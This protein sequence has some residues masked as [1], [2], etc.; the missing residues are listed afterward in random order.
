MRV[1]N[2]FIPFEKLKKGQLFL[3][4]VR[5]P[6]TFVIW[7][8]RDMKKFKA[9]IFDMDG[10]L[11]DTEHYYMKQRE[12]FFGGQGISISH[13]KNA[14]FIGRNLKEMWPEILLGDYEEDKAMALQ[15]AYEI[16][17]HATPLPY[18]ELLFPDVK[19]LLDYLKANHIKMAI[20]SSSSMQDIE[21]CIEKHDLA[22]YF[23]ALY[24]GRN[25]AA[26]KP[27]PAIYKA[28]IKGFGLLPEETLIIEDSQNGI[29]AGKDAGATVYAIADERFGMNQVRADKRMPNL[30][31]VLAQLKSE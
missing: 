16:K 6:N 31:A 13:L 10:V 19:P 4:K 14:D 25:F 2:Q 12:A 17:K 28:A 3:M 21:T 20:A 22:H 29:A 30:T 7:Y 23:S 5:R 18:E 9:V 27:N 11:V 24:S 8:N 1:R 26:S 15:K